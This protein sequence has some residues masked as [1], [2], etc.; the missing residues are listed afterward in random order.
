M[1]ATSPSKFEQSHAR[2]LHSVM[3]TPRTKIVDHTTPEGTEVEI[4]TVLAHLRKLLRIKNRRCSPLLGLPTELIAHILSFCME[5]MGSSPVW[6]PISTICHRIR[7]IMYDITSLWWKVDTSLGREADVVLMRSK[8]A[9]QVVVAEFDPWRFEQSKED[10]LNRW[11]DEWVRQG[12]RL[13]VLEF[14]GSPYD[15][16]SWIFERPLPRLERLKLHVVFGRYDLVLDP[17]AVQLPANMP[18]RVLDLR[19]VTLPWQSD[20][21]A[22]LRELH[23]DFSSVPTSVAKEEFFGIFNASL[24]LERLSLLRLGPSILVDDNL[25][26]PPNPIVRLPVLTFLKLDNDPKIVG[27]ILACMD[28]P[29]LAS[30]ETHSA[31]SGWDITRSLNFFF[32]DGHLPKGLLSSPSVLGARGPH[33]RPHILVLQI[34]GFKGSFHLDVNNVDAIYNAVATCVPLVPPSAIALRFLWTMLDLQKWKDLFKLCPGVRSIE[35]V[36]GPRGE[37]MSISLWEALSPAKDDGEGILCPRL[38]SV[39]FRM[40]RSFKLDPLLSCLRRRKSAGLKLGRFR[41]VDDAKWA[42]K[43]AEEIRP[44]VEVLEVDLPDTT[45]QKVSSSSMLAPGVG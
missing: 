13:R 15:L 30:L 12:D 45:K 4:C 21:F 8:G 20:F 34:G 23:L 9:P 10:V 6:L 1:S 3:T 28:T 26:L 7:E 39:V 35:F 14:Y 18:L 38:E 42:Y 24:Q 37:L 29:A 36:E 25:K 19:N 17:V 2:T 31:G 11:R 44:L 22:G 40:N 5:D 27:Y 32:P 16:F 33:K 43:S 41:I